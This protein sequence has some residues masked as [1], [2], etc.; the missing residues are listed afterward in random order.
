[1]HHVSNRPP[2][3]RSST[4]EP[5]SVPCCVSPVAIALIKRLAVHKA[6]FS[7]KDML[8]KLRVFL[9]PESATSLKL[10]FDN[11]RNYAICGA[12]L[13]Y[14]L[15]V[16]SR[17]AEVE[18]ARSWQVPFGLGTL[19]MSAT[20]LKFT[21]ATALL[22]TASLSIL[23]V[24]QTCLLIF[25]RLLPPLP[26]ALDTQTPP[27]PPGKGVSPFKALALIITFP[28]VTYFAVQLFLNLLAAA[29]AFVAM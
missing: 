11:V 17:G 5:W 7:E 23:N 22:A 6:T 24:L 16:L 15:W 26:T 10:I 4:A 20:E 21:G 14:A 19:Q 13:V 9:M 28:F 27:S 29:A 3:G 12:L 1:M 8:H 18:G 25:H 2:I